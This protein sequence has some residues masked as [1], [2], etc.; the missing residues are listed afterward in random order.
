MKYLLLT[1]GPAYFP[2]L[3]K[4]FERAGLYNWMKA[5]EGEVRLWSDIGRRP[6]E[7]GHYD[8]V[9]VNSFG[10]DQGLAHKV[11]KYTDNLDTKLVVN[12][13]LAIDYFDKDLDLVNFI[14]DVLAADM[15]FGVEPTQVNL[16]NYIGHVMGRKKPKKAVLLPHPINITQFLDN[17]FVEYDKRMDVVAFQFH[18]YD[19]HW[20]IPKM[21]MESLPNK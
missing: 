8:I 12:P 3:L 5:F 20:A 13:D 1:E 17:T 11:S 19:G 4:P 14:R 2:E 7:I 6:Q 15:L 16:I 10:E 18:K 9:H 21:L